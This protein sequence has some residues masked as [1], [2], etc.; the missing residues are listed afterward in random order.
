MT[1][2][3][4]KRRGLKFF[5]PVMSVVVGLMVLVSLIAL[6]NA[7]YLKT[8]VVSDR[9]GGIDYQVAEPPTVTVV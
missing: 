1:K 2:G 7:G 9:S 4:S 8:Q 3:K 5:W 6:Q